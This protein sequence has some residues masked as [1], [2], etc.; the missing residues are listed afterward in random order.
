MVS[1]NNLSYPEV[2]LDEYINA[3][4]GLAVDWVAENLYW[5]DAGRKCIEV[6]RLTGDSRKM[7]ITEDLEEPRSIAVFPSKG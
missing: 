3:P 5:T 6:A 2:L 1:L 7:L 4:D